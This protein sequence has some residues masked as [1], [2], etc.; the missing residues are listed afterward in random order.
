MAFPICKLCAGICLAYGAIFAGSSTIG[1][2]SCSD[3]SKP[4]CRQV[5]KDA[6]NLLALSFVP[7]SVGGLFVA[8]GEFRNEE[9]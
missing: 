2:A 7:L 8:A 3:L 6:A 4:A 9:F 5:Q 1:F